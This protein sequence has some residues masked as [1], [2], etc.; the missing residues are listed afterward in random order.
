[1]KNDP[2]L[3]RLGSPATITIDFRRRSASTASRVVGQRRRRR[4]VTGQRLG[5]LPVAERRR[6][7]RRSAKRDGQHDEAVGIV[8]ERAVAVGETR[9]S[10]GASSRTSPLRRSSTVH[11]ADRL[12]HLL[13]VG[14]D[15]LDRRGA[16]QARD[17]RQA[18][19]PGEIA[20]HRLGDQGVPGLAGG[21]GERDRAAGLRRSAGRAVAMRT[22]RPSKP[23]VGDDQVRAA[24]QDQHGKPARLR[25]A[26][27]RHD[28]VVVA[29]STKM[30]RRPAE[31]QR[32]Q[33]RQRHVVADGEGHRQRIR[34]VAR[35]M[36]RRIPLAISVANSRA[37]A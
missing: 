18:L 36:C 32:R 29:A 6:A 8:F 14:A 9:T 5:E 23:R 10:A 7:A 25:P 3:R 26:Q 27:R 22:T 34:R 21:R 4:R 20:R 28:G 16:D 15:V 35:R 1:M 12:G 31:L 2:T 19:E 24:A 30:A 13:P 11:A 33:R 17:A 37:C